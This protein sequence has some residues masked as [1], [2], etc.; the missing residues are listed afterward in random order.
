MSYLFKDRCLSTTTDLYTFVSADCPVLLSNG[1]TVSCVPTASGV[2][3]T[4]FDPFNAVTTSHSITPSLITCPDLIGDAVTL[5]WQI[6][7]V[8]VTAWAFR[9]LYKVV[10]NR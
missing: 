8:L 5:G 6:V 4:Y 2:D 9:I 7:L 10:T 3:V 1:S